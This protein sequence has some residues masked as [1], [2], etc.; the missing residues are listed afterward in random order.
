MPSEEKLR[1]MRAGG[2]ITSLVLRRTLQ[3]A[4]PGVP[5][6][7][8]DRMVGE[9]ITKAGGR[10]SFKG[11]VDRRGRRYHFVSCINL[12]EGVVHG[13]PR[14]HP[15]IRRGDLVTVDLGVFFK[16]FHTDAAWTIVA[17]QRGEGGKRRFL[18]VGRWALAKAL[19]ECRVGNH[20]G[21]I[22]FAI[23]SVVRRAGYTPVEDLV[24]HG[25]GKRLHEEPP[26]PC[27]GQKGHGRP[28]VEGAT[29]A[30]EVIYTAGSPRLKLDGD[31][32]TLKTADGSWAAL[33]EQTVAVGKKGPLVLTP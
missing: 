7:R 5:T 3:A 33:F 10:P 2:Q 23:G 18:R 28:L 24:G 22:S 11:F 30:V 12:N 29:L 25:V 8:L 15:L 6:A 26:I 4:Q 17:G 20:I 32:W 21:D 19:R 1:A 31:G 14:D 13:V 9:L 16:G 27:Q